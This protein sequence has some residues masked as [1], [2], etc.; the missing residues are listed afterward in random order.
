MTK[1]LVFLV[2][3]VVGQPAVLRAQQFS[4][5]GSA[6]YASLNG[7]DYA[8]INAGVGLDLQ[9]RYHAGR[10]FSVAGGFQYTSHGL[11]GIDESFGVRGY[12]ADARY[13]FAPQS[14]PSVKPYIGGRF[15]VTH[16]SIAAAGTN[17][18]ADGTALG[19][20]GGLLIGL[21]PSTRLDVGLAFLAVRF[22][23]TEFDGVAQPD[24]DTSGST[25]ALRLGVAFNW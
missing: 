3:L 23:D 1:G 6:V 13:T 16:W 19:P 22:G 15:A 5:A 10:G 12:F 25:L 20:V 21:G 2:L 17:A 4:F 9:L 7:D 11:E 14:S 18:T 8:G 24:S